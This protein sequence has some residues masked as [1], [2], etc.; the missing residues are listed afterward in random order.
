[1]KIHYNYKNYKKVFLFCSNFLYIY[2]MLVFV[3]RL[4]N[5][6]TN[7]FNFYINICWK[8]CIR[9]QKSNKN[10]KSPKREIFFILLRKVEIKIYTK[11]EIIYY[12]ML[13]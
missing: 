1:M 12:P 10:D 7:I 8:K 5:Y 13:V 6:T 2:S 11:H 4:V 3:Y 9:K